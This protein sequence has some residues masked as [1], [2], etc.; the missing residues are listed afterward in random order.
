MLAKV[1]VRQP[2]RGFGTVGSVAEP[3]DSI[4]QRACA[5]GRLPKGICAGKD[6]VRKKPVEEVAE[7]QDFRQGGNGAQGMARTATPP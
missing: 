4:F 6:A 5:V 2:A 3:N 7:K 1:R